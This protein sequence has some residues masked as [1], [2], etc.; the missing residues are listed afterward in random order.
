M[1]VAFLHSH[2]D[3][4]T[5]RTIKAHLEYTEG[6]EEVARSIEYVSWKQEDSSVDL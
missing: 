1:D 2:G 3:G 5:L 4:T 6:A